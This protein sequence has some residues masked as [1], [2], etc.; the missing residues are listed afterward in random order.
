MSSTFHV[1]ALPAEL[2]QNLTLR[3]RSAQQPPTTEPN[4]A[5]QQDLSSQQTAT[6]HGSRACNVCLGAT[7]LDVEEQR[8]HF[9]SDWHRY[10][11]KIRLRGGKPTSEVDFAK[12][13]DSTSICT[14]SHAVHLS[15]LSGLE[16]SISGSA[17]DSD[18][19]DTNS[20]DSDTVG[21]LLQRA[22]ITSRPASP[23]ELKPAIPQ[24][25]LAWFHSPP[26]TQIGV[27]KALFPP[28]LDPASY[29]DELKLM[30]TSG[31]PLGR[32]WAMFMTAGGHFAGVIVRVSKPGVEEE[33]SK[34]AKQKR[35]KRT[36][37]DTEVLQHKTFHR[38]TS[39]CGEP[40][41]IV[42]RI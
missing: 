19:D 11:V 33:S 7:F 9:R 17:S 8:V 28:K 12:L 4:N 36:V 10:N 20:G 29:I 30:Q 41:F 14:L 23:S 32:K 15:A 2:L 6:T 24:T 39:T 27:Y 5:E 42:L 22:K 16:D 37:P 31:G 38:Y 34:T 25:P 21:N 13:V 26:S 35:L 40:C 3:S 18:S 1:F